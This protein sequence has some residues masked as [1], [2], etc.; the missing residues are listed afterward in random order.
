L[1]DG[2]WIVATFSIIAGNS[3]YYYRYGSSSSYSSS[4]YCCTTSYY[5]SS[6]S[7]YYTGTCTGNNNNYY[8]S[9]SII[10]WFGYLTGHAAITMVANLCFNSAS[11]VLVGIVVDSAR[12]DERSPLIGSSAGYNGVPFASGSGYG[13]VGA[14]QQA[15]GLYGAA[16]APPP[17][18]AVAANAE[19]GRALVF[20][21]TE[22]AE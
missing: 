4:S 13:G 14:P 15:A 20:M 6:C 10:A 16:A 3:L 8:D 1:L 17:P 11:L 19:A 12:A 22:E 9:S 21:T 18:P 7:A 5:G 2:I